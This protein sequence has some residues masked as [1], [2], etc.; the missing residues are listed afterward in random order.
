MG[1]VI[2]SFCSRNYLDAFN[3][4]IDSWLK[5]SADKIVI[6]TDFDLKADSEKIKIVKYFNPSKDWLVNVGRKVSV[7]A[8]YCKHNDSEQVA[9]LDMDCYVVNDFGEVFSDDY[10]LAVT[11]FFSKRADT[12]TSGVWFTHLNKQVVSFME[13]WGRLE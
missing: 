5:T 6:Y 4:S 2:L 11:R 9:F 12:I 3:F 1:Y 7:S 8:H 10:D 13:E